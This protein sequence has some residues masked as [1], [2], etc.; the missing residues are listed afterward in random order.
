MCLYNKNY[1]NLSFWENSWVYPRYSPT[2]QAFIFTDQGNSD[3][4]IIHYLKQSLSWKFFHCSLG[5]LRCW[6]Y[7]DKISLSLTMWSEESSSLN[8]ICC[9]I[10]MSPK[11]KSWIFI[12][13]FM[14]LMINLICSNS[15]HSALNNRC[16]SRY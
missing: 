14:N 9:V 6:L 12:N 7:I 13:S 15:K 16:Q 1:L 4:W 2:S 8:D 11:F 10:S 3:F 5:S